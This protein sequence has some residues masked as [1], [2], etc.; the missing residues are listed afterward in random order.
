MAGICGKSL[1]NTPL[2]RNK[3]NDGT[4]LENSEFSTGYGLEI[5]ST[6][7]RSYDPQLGRFHQIDPLADVINDH[8]PYAYV[9]NNPLIF[10][11]PYGL[12]TTNGKTPKPNPEPGDIW[13]NDNG[14]SQ[15]FD[16]DR[17]WASQIELTAVM[18]SDRNSESSDEEESG[19]SSFLNDGLWALGIGLNVGEAM[20]QVHGSFIFKKPLQNVEKEIGRGMFVFASTGKTYSQRFRGN[21]YINSNSVRKSLSTAKFVK[22][23]GKGLT[24]LSIS[25][26]LGSYLSSD[27]NGSD[28]ARLIG[29]LIITS[30]AP[31]PI[32]GPVLSI[33][34]GL[35]DSFGAFNGIYDY[36]KE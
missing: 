30:T 26:T 5:Y 35:A 18:L 32:V 28:K 11:D 20:R 1:T 24:I 15:I 13:I 8:T 2:N 31:I 33:G 10:N 34:L 9:L 14:Q 27:K 6:I 22:N 25:T 19:E 23:F 17:G 16:V 29:S 36:F 12:D 4:E 7:Y 3:F 21:Q